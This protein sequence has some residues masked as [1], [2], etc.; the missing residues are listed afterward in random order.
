MGTS[1]PETSEQAADRTGK[2]QGFNLAMANN[3][4]PD[5]VKNMEYFEKKFK[6]QSA[7]TV[8]AT[9]DI[10]LRESDRVIA[11]VTTGPQDRI[12]DK[13]GITTKHALDILLRFFVQYIYSICK[14][15]VRLTLKPDERF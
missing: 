12:L 3:T 14:D 15:M 9:E 11:A 5:D 13:V 4:H 7:E 1:I 8:R 10:I 2:S 6:I